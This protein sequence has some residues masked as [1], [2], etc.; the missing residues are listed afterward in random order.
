M[1][2]KVGPEGK[3]P[4]GKDTNLLHLVKW[5]VMAR[6]SDNSYQQILCFF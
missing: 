1:A 2:P 5:K 3:N 4:V 6:F